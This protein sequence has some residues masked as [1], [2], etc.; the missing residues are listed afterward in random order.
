MLIIFV[1]FCLCLCFVGEIFFF[2]IWEVFLWFGGCLIS[3]M[4]NFLLKS[5]IF[6]IVDMFL[7]LEFI[8]VENNFFFF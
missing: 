1:F 2:V 6:E 4:I 8:F 5:L 7:V 3:L